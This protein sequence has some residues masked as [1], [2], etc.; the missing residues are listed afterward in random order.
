MKDSMKITAV[1][2]TLETLDMPASF[3]NCNKMLGIYGT[4]TELLEDAQAQEEQEAE[5]GQTG[6]E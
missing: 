3:S 4:L 6:A 5:N 1:M 2:N